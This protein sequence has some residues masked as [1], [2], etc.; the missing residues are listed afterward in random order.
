[1]VFLKQDSKICFLTGMLY[2]ACQGLVVLYY[3]E[4]P[5]NFPLLDWSSPLVTI[6]VFTIQSIVFYMLNY[7]IALITQKIHKFVEKDQ[8]KSINE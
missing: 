7:L 5:Y 1:M 8:I 6:G 2:L 4:A 3:N